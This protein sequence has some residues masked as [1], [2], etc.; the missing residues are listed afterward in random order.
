MAK[1]YSISECIAKGWQLT[2]QNKSAPP[3]TAQDLKEDADEWG[4]DLAFL[5]IQF[6]NKRYSVGKHDLQAIQKTTG[7]AT[8]PASAVPDGIGRQDE[9]VFVKSGEAVQGL[10]YTELLYLLEH[11][12]LDK[13]LMP[14]PLLAAA[15]E[16]FR[17]HYARYLAMFLTGE[18]D[19]SL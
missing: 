4:K 2:N 15:Y 14:H 8:I 5:F 19:I 3:F 1:R 13:G 12:R 6:V 18:K 16:D 9:V 17:P 10:S 11:G 7:S